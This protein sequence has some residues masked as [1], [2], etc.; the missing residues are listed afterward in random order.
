MKT[1]WGT[2]I[3]V[4]ALV[5]GTAE[6]AEKAP[7]AAKAAVAEKEAAGTSLKVGDPAPKLQ[8]GKWIQGDKVAAFEKDKVYVVEFWAT[9]CGPCRMTIPHLNEIQTR[10]KDKGLVVIGQNCWEDDDERVPDFV[11]KMGD[12]M[13]Y[14]VAL[15]DKSKFEK[16]AMAATW[17]E[18]AGQGG[19]PTAFVVDQKGRIAWVGHPMDGLDEVVEAVLGGKFDPA[20]EEARREEREKKMAEQRKLIQGVI[21]DA[22]DEKWDDALSKLAAIREKTSGDEATQLDMLKLSLL[23]GKKDAPAAQAHISVLAK[24]A[25]D[26]PELL[27]E[28]AWMLVTS[29]VFAKPDLDLADR[30]ATQAN[31]AAKGG[32]AGVLDTLARVKFMK[33]DKDKAI[34]L[35]TDAVAKA[36]DDDEKAEL[37]KTLQSY[38]DGKLPP[39]AR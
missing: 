33:G 29:E 17:M 5:A 3:I 21:S 15:D 4:A 1:A 20:K 27:N 18:A 6:A 37:G 22:Q 25:G 26:Q 13:T 7:D 9:W 30:I 35:Q 32:V 36:E 11:K 19:I 16:G 38:K 34:E 12:K 39:A 14:R 24:S 23:M 28:L 10:F 8:T 31:D 2:G